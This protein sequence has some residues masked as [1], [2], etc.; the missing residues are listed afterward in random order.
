M[1]GR[2]PAGR[3]VEHRPFI[4]AQQIEATVSGLTRLKLD[5]TLC[6]IDGDF[7]M[8]HKGHSQQA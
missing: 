5:P 2:R 7:E 3:L 8:V 6:L 1:S 4:L